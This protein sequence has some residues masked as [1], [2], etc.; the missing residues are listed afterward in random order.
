MGFYFRYK[1]ILFFCEI[2]LMIIKK[3]KESSI[4]VIYEVVVNICVG[5]FLLNVRLFFL[6][7]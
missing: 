6:I 5:Y 1:S 2:E 7:I 4:F 3:K